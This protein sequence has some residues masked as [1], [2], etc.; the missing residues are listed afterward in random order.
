MKMQYTYTDKTNKDNYELA[1]NSPSIGQAKSNHRPT[2][3][4][5]ES[6]QLETSG[7]IDCILVIL[8]DSPVGGSSL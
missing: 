5:R 8:I 7:H 6:K 2:L 3:T 4:R 1:N